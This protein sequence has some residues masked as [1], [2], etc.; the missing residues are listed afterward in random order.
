[1]KIRL[2]KL[3]L[4]LKLVNLAHSYGFMIQTLCK[5]RF[6][7][8][9]ANLFHGDFMQSIK[10]LFCWQGFDNRQRFILIVLSSLFFFT[11]FSV[12]F[13][14]YALLSSM[15][16]LLCSV[17]CLTTTKRRQNDA[18]FD[19][20]WLIAPAG[21]LFIVG[22]IIVLL[23]YSMSYWLLVFPAGFSLLLLTYPSKNERPYILGYSGPIDL[24]DLQK[25]TKSYSYNSKRVE[26]TMNSIDITS[27]N[28]YPH[29][30]SVENTTR[31]HREN[32]HANKQLEFAES[33]RL[34]LFSKINTRITIAI[35]ISFLV[36]VLLIFTLL[37]N[38]TETNST[39]EQKA[40]HTENSTFEHKLALPD[41]FSIMFDAKNV[42]VVHWK[43]D[44]PDN[45]EVWALGSADGDVSCKAIE[46]NNEL[47]IRTYKVIAKSNGFYAYF[48]PL[49]TKALI[50]N[51][52]FKSN[53]SL[54]GYKFS[55]KGS[56][57]T[58]GKSV[59]YSPLIE[60]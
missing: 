52:A 29:A 10:S 6:F 53:F 22:L 32:I 42:F 18:N 7:R 43:T 48:S 56:Q 12:I 15:V 24:S 49:D 28:E 8:T 16:L 23:S 47:P 41:N 5:A 3:T 37:S 44:I 33:I 39:V 4:R 26:P 60:Y 34:T 25:K 51:I 20:K 35:I 55:L 27:S 13:S 54:C 17:I 40:P 1:M 45:N 14:G 19:N 2:D 21:S 46:F 57:A 38:D 11:T 36:L 50:K 9:L 59:F 30:N 31:E 58:L